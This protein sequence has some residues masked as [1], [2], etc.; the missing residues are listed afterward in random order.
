MYFISLI[1]K[2]LSEADPQKALIRALGKVMALRNDP[3]HANEFAMFSSFMAEVFE[4]WRI[5]EQLSIEATKDIIEDITLQLTADTVVASS[6]DNVL[7]Q[8]MV[9]CDMYWT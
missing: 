5:Q 3:R 8:G 7:V 6:K 2:A 9:A 1:Q 4:T